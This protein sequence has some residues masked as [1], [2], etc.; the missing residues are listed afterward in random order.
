MQAGSDRL[1]ERLEIF[2]YKPPLFL[3]SP[4]LKQLIFYQKRLP[5]QRNLQTA[6]TDIKRN[7]KT[8]RLCNWKDASSQGQ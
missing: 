6:C 3:Y 2:I 7:I 4:S 5:E 1:L 8:S